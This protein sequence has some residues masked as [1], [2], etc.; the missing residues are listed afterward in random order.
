MILGVGGGGVIRGD[1]KEAEKGAKACQLKR[2]LLLLRDC[3]T[4]WRLAL[5]HDVFYF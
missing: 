5:S 1:T 3:L 4:R 2:V